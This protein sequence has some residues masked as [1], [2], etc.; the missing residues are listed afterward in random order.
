VDGKPKNSCAVPAE[1][2]DGKVVL[3]LEG[4]S[5]EEKK[6]YSD[7]FQAAAGLQCG[8]C[9]PGLTLRIKWLTDQDKLM[10]R[11]DIAKALDGHLCRC[12][13]YV[14]IV[15][16]VELVFAAKRGG[17]LPKP[18]EDGGV[19]ARLQRYQGAELAV[20]TRRFVADLEAPRMLHGAVTL[21][22]HA[23]AKVLAVDTSKA[24]ALT[25]VVAVATAKDVPGDRWVGLIY[26]DWPVFVA[27][28]EEVRAVGDVVAAV[29]A[30]TPEIAR[31]AAGLVEVSYE[32]L[33][34][35]LDPSKAIEPGAPQVNPRHA[36][37]LSTT[38]VRR[39][40][41]DAAKA[42]S[43]T[44]GRWRRCWASPSRTSTSSWCR[45]AAPSAARRT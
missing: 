29:A 8:F 30:E 45:T 38:K 41:A 6:L 16:A 24:R 32:L 3:T 28:G 26:P 4:V 22:S 19:G 18:L 42:S 39:G 36:N 9:T 7:A 1:K 31:A 40:D 43:T 10:S 27:E 21:S 20:G 33:P 23:R 11:A 34:P 25:G 14:K 44:A 5:A 2:V 13:G 12:T 37:V 17:A 35:V 15:D